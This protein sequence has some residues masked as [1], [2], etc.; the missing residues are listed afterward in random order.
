MDSIFVT[1]WQLEQYVKMCC[2]VRGWAQLLH[3][4]GGSWVRRWTW[5]RRECPIG[6]LIMTC[7]WGGGM[8]ASCRHASN[9][10]LAPAMNCHTMCYGVISSCQSAANSKIVKC[11]WALSPDSCKR[12]YGKFS[13]HCFTIAMSMYTTTSI[14]D[15][16]TIYTQRTPQSAL[17]KPTLLISSFSLEKNRHNAPHVIV[18]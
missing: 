8:S 9:C 1:C 3:M 13:D 5:V 14:T 6:S 12:H 2:I 10:L 4:G 11:F 18:H 16:L 7:S 17:V 15:S